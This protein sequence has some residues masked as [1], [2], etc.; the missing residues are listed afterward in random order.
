VDVFCAVIQPFFQLFVAFKRI[1]AI[2]LI[3]ILVVL[4]DVNVFPTDNPTLYVTLL[5]VGFVTR[6]KRLE[7]ISLIRCPI[8]KYSL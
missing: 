6:L 8:Q 3:E 1:E 2:H 5:L 7:K 4:D